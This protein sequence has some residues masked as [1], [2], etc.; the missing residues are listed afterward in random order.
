LSGSSPKYK[1]A[2][3]PAPW[4][5]LFCQGDV[6]GRIIFNGFATAKNFGDWI[7]NFSDPPRQVKMKAKNM[8]RILMK[9]QPLAGFADL[10]PPCGFCKTGLFQGLWIMCKRNKTGPFS[11]FEEARKMRP[12]ALLSAVGKM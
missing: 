12:K 4:L 1:G 5:A 6:D 9:Y 2:G 3:Y 11:G 8:A 10:H 7:L